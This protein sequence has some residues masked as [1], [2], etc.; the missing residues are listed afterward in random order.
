MY[1]MFR[2]VA[3]GEDTPANMELLSGPDG[4]TALGDFYRECRMMALDGSRSN[5][6]CFGADARSLE[7]GVAVWEV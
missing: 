4:A 7:R 3:T 5:A 6:R 1:P 2:L